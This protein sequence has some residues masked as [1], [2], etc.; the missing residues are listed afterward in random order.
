METARQVF[1][2]PRPAG[3]PPEL[4]P[5]SIVLTTPGPNQ[6]SFLFDLTNGGDITETT[7]QLSKMPKSFTNHTRPGSNIIPL[8]ESPR[9]GAKAV[10]GIQTLQGFLQNTPTPR[11]EVLQGKLVNPAKTEISQDFIVRTRP[12]ESRINKGVQPSQTPTTQLNILTTPSSLNSL[13]ILGDI[14]NRPQQINTVSKNS[15]VAHKQ[16]FSAE[17]NFKPTID[18]GFVDDTEPDQPTKSIDEEIHSFFNAPT[19]ISLLNSKEKDQSTG[20]VSQT[21]GKSETDDFVG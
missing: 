21:S 16:T 13:G 19:V 20:L 6:P 3:P 18:F 11:T 2:P 4:N 12:T 8:Q 17:N 14:T 15:F 5:A 10:S 9:S 1:K 7:N